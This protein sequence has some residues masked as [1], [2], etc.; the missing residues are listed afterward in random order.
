[1]TGEWMTVEQSNIGTTLMIAEYLMR[2][3]RIKVLKVAVLQ[4][5]IF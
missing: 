5:S 3:G 1:M 4:I 2:N